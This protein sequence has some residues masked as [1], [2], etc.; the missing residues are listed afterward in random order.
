MMAAILREKPTMQIQ[1]EEK[2][3]SANLRISQLIPVSPS[4]LL[5]PG[6]LLFSNDFTSAIAVHGGSSC[7]L[8]HH[9]AHTLTITTSVVPGYSAMSARR[10]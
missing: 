9:P 1:I 8:G 4:L 10:N 2:T 7:F 5:L 6:S 3:G